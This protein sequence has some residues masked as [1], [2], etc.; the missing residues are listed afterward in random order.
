MIR[1]GFKEDLPAVLNLIKEL[2]EFEK[3]PHEV[4][5][6]LQDMEHDGF[7]ENPIFK[8]F[9]AEVD[10]KI[11][12]M[13]LYFIKYS[14]W[15][16]KCVYLDDI[17]VTQPY[18]RKGIGK[19]LFEAVVKATVEMRARRLE[20]Q[21]L[22]WNTPAI[23]FYKQ[24]DSKFMKAWLSCRLTDEQLNKFGAQLKLQKN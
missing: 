9:V 5:V 2:A 23:E 10:K 14:T 21:V 8:F 11:V 12:G 1:K 13:A 3:E 19:L 7:G 18:R 16:G 22:D 15:K 20:W 6:T 17:I 24:Y 4:V